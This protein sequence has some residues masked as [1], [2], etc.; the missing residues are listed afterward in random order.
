MQMQL[1]NLI[2]KVLGVD[3]STLTEDSSAHNTP[4]W[5]SLRHIEILF[6]VESVFHVRFTMPEISGL[7]ELS[8]IRRL[9]LAKRVKLNT[10]SEDQLLSA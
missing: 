2:G 1:Y 6:A 8:D 3:P 10:A 9:L 4:R 5:D 7:R